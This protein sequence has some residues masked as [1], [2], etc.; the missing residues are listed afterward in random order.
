MIFGQR[1]QCELRTVATSTSLRVELI[2]EG[3]NRFVI[4]LCASGAPRLRVVMNGRTVRHAWPMT[5]GPMRAGAHVDPFQ[6]ATRWAYRH[7]Y[8]KI[9]GTILELQ[10]DPLASPTMRSLYLALADLERVAADLC[11][12]VAR[13]IALRF[14]F[15]LRFWV[16]ARVVEDPTGRI[17]QLSISCPGALSFAYGLEH[18][19]LK[20]IGGPIGAGG[21]LLFDVIRGRKLDSIL[22]DALGAWE[23][24]ASV[25]KN[26]TGEL[27]GIWA[28]VADA[29]GGLREKILLQQRLLIRLAGPLV[30]SLSLY[31]PPP[32]AFAP[33]DVPRGARNN[34][35]WFR[36]V[37][38]SSR[39]IANPTLGT[40]SVRLGLSGFVSRNAPTLSRIEGFFSP[41]D[42]VEA[43]EDYVCIANR[44]ISRNSNMD[45]L[46][47][48]VCAWN[49]QIS[50]LSD[51]ED[52]F[53]P[54][55]ERIF[56]GLI[57]I[58]PP[59]MDTWLNGD[60]EIVPITSVQELINEG[61]KMHNC[62][63]SRLSRIV[64][65]GSYIY[66]ATIG[67]RR[68]TVEIVR[69]DAAWTLGEVAG[70]AHDPVESEQRATL[71]AWLNVLRACAQPE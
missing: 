54:S 67:G 27:C 19:E 4:D 20:S 10:P 31:L 14:P 9:K 30:G 50:S 43:L 40:E 64:R 59:P 13:S 57:E 48:N 36:M 61:L 69:R 17:A 35:R 34:A 12:P 65:G 47:K 56:M 1:Q 46:V 39:L 24:A 29:S 60:V 6:L 11:D 5:R 55:I 42:F 63:V 49:E 23:R 44:C 28:R 26:S 52:A 25:P 8:P 38:C 51:V 70:F 53:A 41:R 15:H 66:R 7:M 62:V 68:F 58:P 16:Y 71:N 37:K 2:G 45:E 3:R 33:E 22:Q 21:R 32:L 18:A